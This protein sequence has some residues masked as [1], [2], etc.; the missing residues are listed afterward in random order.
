MP[1]LTTPAIL[2]ELEARRMDLVRESQLADS[3]AA[4]LSVLVAKAH[5][6]VNPTEYA[7]AC[8]IRD[9]HRG[10]RR[11]QAARRKGS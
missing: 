3:L 9:Y 4:S 2:E 8:Q 10:L 6:T 5:R 11:Q 1:R 7:R